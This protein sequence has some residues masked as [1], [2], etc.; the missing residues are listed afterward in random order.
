MII[1]GN[2]RSS[3][4]RR[5]YII[6]YLVG[7]ISSSE[8]TEEIWYD[9]ELRVSEDLTTGGVKLRYDFRLFFSKKKKNMAMLIV[10]ET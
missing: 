5:V 7:L 1:D 2:N 8:K 4:G 3:E 6:L 9:K 10:P